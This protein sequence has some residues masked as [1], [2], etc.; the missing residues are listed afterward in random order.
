VANAQTNAYMKSARA[1]RAPR[2]GAGEYLYPLDGRLLSMPGRCGVVNETDWPGGQRALVVV[3]DIQP[4]SWPCERGLPTLIGPT[5]PTL[6]AFYE[7]HATPPTSAVLVSDQITYN[8]RAAPTGTK[9]LHVVV[10]LP[11]SRLL[12]RSSLRARITKATAAG[13]DRPVQ[14]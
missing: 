7:P 14:R 1:R 12:I 2:F 3:H 5:E 10:G 4:K 9:D 11:E 8:G 6:I 13:S